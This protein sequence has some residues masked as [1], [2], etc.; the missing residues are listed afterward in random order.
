MPRALSIA[1]GVLMIA[2]VLGTT[3]WLLIWSLKRS[4]DPA[5]LLFKWV[6]TFV[7]IGGLLAIVMKIG[8]EDNSA[9]LIPGVCAIFGVALGIT[10]APH[11]GAIMARPFTAMFD[12]GST[13]PDPKPFYSVAFARRKQGRY[14]EAVKEI[15]EQLQRFPDDF[16]GQIMLAQIQA[17]DLKDLAGAQQIIQRICNQERHSPAQIS[18]ALMQLADWQLKYWQDP[19][20]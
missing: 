6:L 11:W 12:G 14:E 3:V 16:T 19:D 7:F 9:M 2:T 15:Q 17:E 1:I 10:W 8:F 18:G 20:S 5:K 13:P 4:E